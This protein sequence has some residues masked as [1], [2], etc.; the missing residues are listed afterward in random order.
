MAMGEPHA[1][2]HREEVTPEEGRRRKMLRNSECRVHA[3]V[4]M[5]LAFET[6]RLFP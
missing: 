4:S 2:R 1:R 6:P 3:G 5:M